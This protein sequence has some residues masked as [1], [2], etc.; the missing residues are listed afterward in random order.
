L[1]VGRHPLNGILH[2]LRHL[3]VYP[4]L[5]RCLSIRAGLDQPHRRPAYCGES[6][7][8][9]WNSVVRPITTRSFR[10]QDEAVSMPSRLDGNPNWRPI[11]FD[12][13]VSARYVAFGLSFTQLG[14]ASETKV[15]EKKTRAGTNA[16][17]HKHM[18]GL[19]SSVLIVVRRCP[20][21]VPDRAA[22]LMDQTRGHQ[23][24]KVNPI[25]MCW[26]HS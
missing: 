10:M 3:R 7:C 20:R 19:H 18:L 14:I 11:P 4:L 17:E 5:L 2:F 15:E 9:L 16:L 23:L 21:G 25:S 22:C 13:C 12:V 24:D 26:L 6:L 1:W 8:C